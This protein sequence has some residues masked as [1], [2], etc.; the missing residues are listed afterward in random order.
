MKDKYTIKQALDLINKN[1]NMH[2]AS[3]QDG[4]V[5]PENREIFKALAT[6]LFTVVAIL[7]RVNSL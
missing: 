6:E 3:S 7:K 2:A 5:T 4:Q 1:A